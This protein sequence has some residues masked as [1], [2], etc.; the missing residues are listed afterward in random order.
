MSIDEVY[1]KWGLEVKELEM[2]LGSQ[3]LMDV[4][5]LHLYYTTKKYILDVY[6]WPNV[7]RFSVNVRDVNDREYNISALS[8]D[9]VKRGGV[10]DKELLLREIKQVG[11]RDLP[12]V[13]N[14]EEIAKGIYEANKY[15][16]RNVDNFRGQCKKLKRQWKKLERILESEKRMCA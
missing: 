4:P 12:K 10:K 16:D 1:G 14:L 13:I 2:S 9:Q 6:A 5:I 8:P 15:M 7:G 11:C 3:K